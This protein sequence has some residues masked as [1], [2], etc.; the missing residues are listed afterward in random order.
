VKIWTKV[1]C[2][3]FMIH[4]VYV[5]SLSEVFVNVCDNNLVEHFQYKYEPKSSTRFV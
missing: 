1:Q 5:S 2:H 3:V 4:S